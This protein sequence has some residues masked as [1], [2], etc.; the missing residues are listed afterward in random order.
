MLHLCFY[1]EKLGCSNMLLHF[2]FVIS[3]RNI[4][5]MKKHMFSDK[6]NILKSHTKAYMLSE[7]TATSILAL[8]AEFNLIGKHE[9]R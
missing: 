5:S 9:A 4:E 7:R 2:F 1:M 6:Y 8:H 3:V